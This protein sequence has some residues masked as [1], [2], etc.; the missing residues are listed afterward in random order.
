MPP[1]KWHVPSQK[2]DEP[3]NPN[4]SAIPSAVFLTI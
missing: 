2:V 1:T 4:Q 3:K